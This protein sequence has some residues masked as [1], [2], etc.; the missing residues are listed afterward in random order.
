LETLKALNSTVQ[1]QAR[2][3]KEEY[4]HEVCSSMEIDNDR[5]KTRDML[6]KLNT[7]TGKFIPRSGMYKTKKNGIVTEEENA[8]R[9]GR[10]RSRRH[11]EYTEELY[12]KYEN[13]KEVYVGGEEEPDILESEV[14]KVLQEISNDKAAGDDEIP[15]ELLK[16]GED[17][18]IKV[19]TALCQSVWKTGI[20][21]KDWKTSICTPMHKKGI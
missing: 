7:I 12:K 21:L 5:G 3:D 2:K 18:S 17:E 10:R 16:G 1:A 8:K 15:V 13:R 19:L 14:R 9:D 6:K 11:K 4:F 20:W